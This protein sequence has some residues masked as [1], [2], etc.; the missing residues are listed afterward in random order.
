MKPKMTQVTVLE[1]STGL[2]PFSN[3]LAAH[4]ARRS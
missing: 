4:Y 3:L 2:A 1:R